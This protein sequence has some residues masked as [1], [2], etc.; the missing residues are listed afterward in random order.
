MGVP[1]MQTIRVAIECEV[2]I[3]DPAAAAAYAFD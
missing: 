3:T 2:E 1:L